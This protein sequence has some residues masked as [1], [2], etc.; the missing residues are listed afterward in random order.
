MSVL[1]GKRRRACA[2]VVERRE[3]G[4]GEAGVARCLLFYFGPAKGGP[5]ADQACPVTRFFTPRRRQNPLLRPNVARTAE[6]GAG[7]AGHAGDGRSTCAR[8]PLLLPISAMAPPRRCGSWVASVL[9]S[10]GRQDNQLNTWG[11]VRWSVVGAG[12]R[13]GS[14]AAG[15]CRRVSRAHGTLALLPC[16]PRRASF[17]AQTPGRWRL[18]G[19]GAKKKGRLGAHGSGVNARTRGPRTTHL[20]FFFGGCDFFFAAERPAL[21]S[22]SYPLLRAPSAS[23]RGLPHPPTPPPGRQGSPVSAHTP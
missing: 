23:C 4:G 9:A 6:F 18:K 19:G 14:R 5:G 2:W 22:W 15:K 21:L 12:V 7:R 3:S 10:L 13:V 16:G 11:G 8:T 20:F 1:G 17:Y